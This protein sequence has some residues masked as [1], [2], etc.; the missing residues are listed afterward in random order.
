MENKQTRYTRNS[1][2][3]DLDILNAIGNE[4]VHKTKVMFAAY[5][6][7]NNFDRHLETLVAGGFVHLRVDGR[8]K[9]LFITPKGELLRRAL[10]TV[11]EL[12]VGTEGD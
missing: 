8:Y 3:V 10:D 7:T 5:V 12:Y 11:S 2:A 4:E 6:D 1:W 9:Y